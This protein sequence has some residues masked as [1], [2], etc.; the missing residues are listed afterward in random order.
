MQ[1]RWN[2]QIFEFLNIFAKTFQGTTK[3]HLL[4]KKSY[5]ALKNTLKKF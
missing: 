4:N 1:M 5:N 3:L 2:M